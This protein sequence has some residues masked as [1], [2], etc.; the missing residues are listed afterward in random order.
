MAVDF[1][2]MSDEELLA[3]AQQE[4][5][6]STTPSPSPIARLRAVQE[7]LT[8]EIIETGED[9]VTTG[10]RFI[11]DPLGITDSKDTAERERTLGKQRKDKRE[12]FEA[13]GLGTEHTVGGVAGT[14]AEL[15]TPGGAATRAARLAKSGIQGLALGTVKTQG[16]AEE[17]I[18]A[19]LQESAAFL[20]GDVAVSKLGKVLK[21]VRKSPGVEKAFKDAGVKPLASQIATGTKASNRLRTV[22][23]F[24]SGIPIVGTKKNIVNQFRDLSKSAD[25][26]SKHLHRE[27][28][29]EK[30]VKQGF[31]SLENQLKNVPVNTA[32]LKQT[33]QRILKKP[34]TGINKEAQKDFLKIVKNLDESLQGPQSFK[35]ARELLSSLDTKIK[36]VNKAAITGQASKFSAKKANILRKQLDELIT[37]SAKDAGRGNHYAAL[38]SA[39]GRIKE[40][41]T[42]R[43][44]LENSLEKNNRQINITTFRSGIKKA[45]KNKQITHMQNPEVEKMMKGIRFVTGKLKGATEP[46]RGASLAGQVGV[47]VLLGG[48]ALYAGLGSAEVLIPAGLTKGIS[49]LIATPTGQKL[50]MKAGGGSKIASKIF[51]LATK[52]GIEKIRREKQI[53]DKT[54]NVN[55]F[56]SMSD[57]QLLQEAK[58]LG[59]R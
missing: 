45:L 33:I 24:M 7:G 46:T 49:S 44:I 42:L 15:A 53:Q 28:Q 22:E 55:A 57:E 18:K 59:I 11:T 20:A 51:L 35:S 9:L 25:K 10:R 4:G 39:N 47:G 32:P 29:G 36:Q 41:K 2:N 38:R 48:G 58:R 21:R 34:P 17:K 12:A 26:V 14:I 19:G 54:N 56:D 40:A 1:N 3:I 37:Q 27:I 5:L 16:T 8:G 52:L 43:D 50:L 23:N 30:I 13:A 6:R 31:E